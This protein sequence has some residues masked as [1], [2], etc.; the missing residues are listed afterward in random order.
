MP[1]YNNF[2][3]LML[4]TVVLAIAALSTAPVSAQATDLLQVYHLA[5]EFDPEYQSAIAAHLAAQ[6]A[7]PQAIAG[8]LPNVS[9]EL[10]SRGNYVNVQES[11]SIFSGGAGQ[12]RFHSNDFNIQFSH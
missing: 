2:Q 6:E 3:S 9:A 11:A 1:Q 4:K 7:V 8:L 10:T 5:S 12:S